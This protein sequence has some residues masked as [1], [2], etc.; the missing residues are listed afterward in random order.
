[1]KQKQAAEDKQRS[2][3]V[4]CGDNV[5]GEVVLTNPGS[6]SRGGELNFATGSLDHEQTC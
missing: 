4:G 6:R 5:K 2:C 3:R 1:M